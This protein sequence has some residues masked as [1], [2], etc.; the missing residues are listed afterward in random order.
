MQS[1]SSFLLFE[2]LESPYMV[3]LTCYDT[4]KESTKKYNPSS[5]FLQYTILTVFKTP[6]RHVHQKR[7]F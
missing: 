2:C 1:K 5:I 6:W 7:C 4:L 3:A